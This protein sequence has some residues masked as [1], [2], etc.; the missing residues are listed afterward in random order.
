MVHVD[1][2]RGGGQLVRTAVTLS[3][4]TGD[5]VRVEDV[6]AHRSNPGLRPQHVAAVETIAEICGADTT[7]VSV[8]ADA[9][10]FDP[11]EIA[12]DDVSV[13]IGTAGSIALVFDTVLPVAMATREPFSVDVTGGTHVKWAPTLDYYRTVKLPVLRRYGVRATVT[14]KRTGFYPA[15]GGNA[16]IDIEPSRMEP[17]DLVDHGTLDAITIHSIAHTTLAD[18]D[19]AERQ[20]D[21]AGR[22]LDPISP[23]TINRDCRYV[24]A[25]S[26]GSA[27][28]VA[29]QYEHVTA[30]F[31]AIGERGKPAETVAT[32]AVEAALRY[33]HGPGVVDRY[34]ADQLLV[35]LAFTGGVIVVP[36][37]TRHVD[38]SLHLLETFGFDLAVESRSSGLAITSE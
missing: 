31:S 32:D 5:A 19:V 38:S 25:D 2:S 34:L 18:A 36:E 10:T 35:S 37:R 30:G 13:T 28:L 21:T 8:G 24:K 20:A 12:P 15:G 23:G 3:T 4:L 33:H 17:F 29:L 11:G 9:F 22:D 1:G 26:P 7:G 16:V 14:G 6:R 27:L